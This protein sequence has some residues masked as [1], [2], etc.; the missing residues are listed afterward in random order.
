M[1]VRSDHC[2]SHQGVP[3]QL[4]ELP[5]KNELLPMSRCPACPFSFHPATWWVHFITSIL[6]VKKPRPRETHLYATASGEPEFAP[7]LPL[8]MPLSEAFPTRPWKG[9]TWTLWVLTCEESL[10][11]LGLAVG[12]VELCSWS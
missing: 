12:E 11:D 3:E 1:V 7:V 8:P 4:E 2:L 6:W 5:W 9:R 10:F